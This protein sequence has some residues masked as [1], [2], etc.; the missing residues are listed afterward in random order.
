M[1]KR[2]GQ[3]SW[4]ECRTFGLLARMIDRLLQ[5][6][7]VAGPIVFEQQFVRI[8]I[9]TADLMFGFPVAAFDKLL[10]QQRDVFFALSQ[11]E[12]FDDLNA[13]EVRQRSV[14][15]TPFGEREQRLFGRC[16]DPQFKIRK[17][18]VSPKLRLRF[19]AHVVNIQQQQ[20]IL[21]VAGSLIKH[22]FFDADL[23]QF[24]VGDCAVNGDQ[25]NLVGVAFVK[26]STS[27]MFS[28]RSLGADD[29]AVRVVACYR[30]DL[31]LQSLRKIARTN[32]ACRRIDSGV[33]QMQL[34]QLLV[35]F[36][37]QLQTFGCRSVG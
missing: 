3:V 5:L 18:R 37:R 24:V 27:E 23:D 2:I 6:V 26:N 28:P 33:F 29:Q 12:Q 34:S 22:P 8:V 30:F 13:Q 15:L 17:L 14:V 1:S 4:F 11:R 35:Q 16:Y 10:C 25:S 20:P 36:L 31:S 21:G 9:D 7:D 19:D 32:Q